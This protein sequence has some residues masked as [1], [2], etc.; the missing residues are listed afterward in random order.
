MSNFPGE[1]QK[2]IDAYLAALRRQLHE[3]TDED[4]RDIVEEIRSHIVDRAG[5]GASEASVA[6]TLSGLGSPAELARKYRTDELL[7]RGAMSRAPKTRAGRLLRWVWMGLLA[8]MVFAVSIV[9]YCLGGG[10]V[11]AGTIKLLNPRYI[12]LWTHHA[13]GTWGWGFGSLPGGEHDLLGW[14][15]VPISLISGSILMLL[16]FRFGN[17]CLR[18]FWRPRAWQRAW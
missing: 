14:W 6:A 17:W 5:S 9:G 8:I 4:V 15:L 18:R 2:A 7:R 10:L 13:D 16:T 1:S 12:G 11:I 3:L